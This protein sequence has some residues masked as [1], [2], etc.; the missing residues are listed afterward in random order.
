M[1]ATRKGKIKKTPVSE[2][3]SIRSS[4]K[5]AIK[6]DEDDQ[7]VAATF[8]KEGDQVAEGQEIL[9]MEAMKMETPVAAPAAGTVH[10]LVKQGDQIQ[11]GHA[12]AEIK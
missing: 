4:G 7:L 12:L 5:I 6:M 10:F 8:V 1:L 3:E 11:T 2:F 9:V